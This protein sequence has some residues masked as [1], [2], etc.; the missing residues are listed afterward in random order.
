MPGH[1]FHC[2]YSR[3][4]Q[5]NRG[6]RSGRGNLLTSWHPGSEDRREYTFRDVSSDLL[7]RLRPTSLGSFSSQYHHQLGTQPP[8]QELWVTFKIQTITHSISIGLMQR[9]SMWVTKHTPIVEETW[10][11]HLVCVR[12]WE[13]RAKI[14]LI[15]IKLS[16]ARKVSILA[17]QEHLEKHV[18][19]KIPRLRD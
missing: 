5:K 4:R 3:L 7:P 9:S 1:W 13:Q 12:N 6:R 8:T 17:S 2:F 14:F 15:I 16:P 11:V 18:L 10:R 19:P